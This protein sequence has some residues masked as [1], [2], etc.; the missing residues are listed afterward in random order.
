[1]ASLLLNVTGVTLVVD[2]D[3]PCVLT[4]AGLGD[5]NLSAGANTIALDLD[6]D[7][8]NLLDLSVVDPVGNAASPIYF[9]ITTDLTAP[10]IEILE[11]S[12]EEVLHGA[13]VQ[14]RGATE[15]GAN[16]TI[17]GK[18]C[19]VSVGGLFSAELELESGTNR[20]VI[21]AGDLAGN[22]A[23][24]TIDLTYEPEGPVDEGDDGGGWSAAIVAVVIAAAIA[25]ALILWRSRTGGS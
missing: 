22:V 16:L 2:V 1:V 14:L 19:P 6:A 12:L 23:S 24:I 20:I 15:E 4:I 7:A 18:T 3:E 10:T 13:V 5:H 11:P 21:T 8:V 17:D 25:V 9:N